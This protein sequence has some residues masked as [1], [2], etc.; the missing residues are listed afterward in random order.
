MNLS[1]IYPGIT[2][3]DRYG[4]D[5]GEIGGRQAPLGILYLAAWLKRAGHA[6]QV[7]DAE[8]ERLSDD[9]VEQR[10]ANFAPDLVGLSLTTVAA[11]AGKLLAKRLRMALPGVP[12]VVGGPHVTADPDDALSTGDFDLGIVGEGEQPL[13]EVVANFANRA[14]WRMLPGVAWRDDDGRV[15]VNPRPERIVNLDS[16]PWPA[17][18]ELSSLRLYRPPLGCYREEPVVSL[19]TSRGCP[20]GCIFCDNN[21]FG[22]EVRFFSPEY[23][24]AEIAE[25]L[26]LG[27]RELTFVDDTFPLNRQRFTRILDLIEVGG[28]R[29]PWTCMANVNDLDEGLLRRMRS[30][31]CWQIAVG[32]ESG[33]ETIL[34]TIRKGISLER[35][36]TTVVAAHRAGI[37]V[38]GFF[39]LGHPGETPETLRR[40]RDLAL[41]LPFTDVVCTLATPIR[42]TAFH[43][44]VKDGAFGSFEGDAPTARL[45]YWEPVFVPKDL[46]ADALYAAQREFYRRFYLR[47]GVLLRQIRKFRRP[48]MLC[49]A[50]V[51]AGKLL[52]LRNKRA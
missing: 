10:V 33:D 40:T 4:A 22:R 43:D 24:A 31:G 37:L 1:L 2:V 25:A 17:R 9:A 45:N 16:L 30:L 49:R 46:T 11:A 18:E 35:I 23:V 27:A 5:I 8:A 47:P 36:R 32:I 15:Q 28:R 34:K 51:T 26:R 12:L 19:I 14:A 38:K 7:V 44:L 41:S 29:F 20:Y 3:L 48:S 39:M 50:I 42:G 52:R 6:V 13:A 21:T